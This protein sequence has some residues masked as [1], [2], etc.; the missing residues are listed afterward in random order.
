MRVRAID[1]S[2]H[3]WQFG[4]GQNDYRRDNDAVTQN[5]STRL[6]SFLGDCFFDV[7]AGIDWFNRLGS[8][9]LLALKLDIASTIL[10]TTFVTGILQLEISLD[11]NRL[12]TVK[13]LV[14]TSYSTAASTFIFD[15]SIG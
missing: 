10:N 12:L 5:I 4:K 11:A 2:D 3:D 7:G 14:R 9:D 1:Y 6:Y 15:T 13:Y 8:K